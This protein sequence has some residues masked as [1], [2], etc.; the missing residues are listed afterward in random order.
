[1]AATSSRT[2][3]ATRLRC[4]FTTTR[5]PDRRVAECTWAMEAAATGVRSIDVNTSASGRPR[6]SSIVRRTT[7][8]G[9]GGTRSRRSRNS[10]TSSS[11]KI[12]SPDEMIWPS[13][14]YV[15]PRCSNAGRNRRDSPARDCGVP[16]SLAPHSTRGT[17][18]RHATLSTR[19]SDGRCWGWTS[20][21]A[22]SAAWCRS[23][24][25]SGS[26]RPPV[27]QDMASGST[28][29]GASGVKAPRT[30]SV[31]PSGTDGS[32]GTGSIMGTPRYVRPDRAGS[33]R[34]PAV[35][36]GDR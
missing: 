9:S 34:C 32:V 2:S 23:V 28:S 27:R 33:P 31:G 12:P 3:G 11:G 24:S 18:S 30:R 15:G 1:M 25:T 6:S 5:S 19:P 14:M 26:P 13:L 8:N 10:F 35:P 4:T 16:R 17:P 36:I 21:R 7:A 20:V 29:H 22:R